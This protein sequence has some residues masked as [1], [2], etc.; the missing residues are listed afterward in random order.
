MV[1]IV[2]PAKRRADKK[3]AKALRREGLLPAV[4]YGHQINSTPITLDA[5]SAGLTLA[6]VSASTIVNIE[7]DGEIHAAL[8][9]ERQKDYV[10]N[11]LIHVDFQV[12]SLTEKIRATVTLYFEGV[13]PAVKDYNGVIVNNLNQVEVEALPQDLPE[14]L[15]VDLSSLKSIGDN[16]KVADLQ[17]PPNAEMLTDLDEVVVVVSAMREEVEEL[18]EEVE[19]A[20]PELI[21]RGKREEEI[22]D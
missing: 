7:V 21:E 19:L 3:T 12:V 17:L 22:E 15:M 5:H 20:E 13:S 16:I 11:A 9:R 8:V 6:G 2:I 10:R 1:K 18:G 14:R 4:M